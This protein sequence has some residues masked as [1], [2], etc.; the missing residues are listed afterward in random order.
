MVNNVKSHTDGIINNQNTTSS[1]DE[2]IATF[3]I[4]DD[5]LP[6]TN[7]LSYHIINSTNCSLFHRFYMGKFWNIFPI[8]RAIQKHTHRKTN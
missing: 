4:S 6:E 3:Y 8:I 5:D 1:M 7:H 2:N